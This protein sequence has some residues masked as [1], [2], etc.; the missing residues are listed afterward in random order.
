MSNAYQR[1]WGN[2]G[3]PG[4]AEA[5]AY[6]RAHIVKVVA[7][8][9]GLFVRAE[10]GPLFVG[11]LDELVASGYALDVRA[12]DWGYNNRPK[13]GYEG[14]DSLDVRSNHAWG[15]A[16][17][18][19]ATTNPMTNDG[20]THTD[21]PVEIVR[22]LAI[23]WGLEWGGDYSGRRRDPMHFEFLGRPGDEELYP[24][25]DT[26]PPPAAQ[27]TED[28]MPLRVVR[29]RDHPT[30]GEFLTNCVDSVRTL[31]QAALIH[32]R[33]LGYYP[34]Q[35]DDVPHDW[36]VWVDQVQDGHHDPADV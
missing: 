5:V 4:S 1:G 33:N 18:V 2:P 7:G 13:R 24:L 27:P 31:T 16:V 32:G 15:L 36:I 23:K 17:D 14:N 12:D 26:P 8:G 29:C 3:A 28:D 34:A 35:T 30:A 19:N 20:V 9:V 25:A 21:M 11:L 6:R 22:H 10:V